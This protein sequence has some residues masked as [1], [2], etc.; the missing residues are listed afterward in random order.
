VGVWV[1]AVP[2]AFLSGLYFKWDVWFVVAAISMEEVVKVTLTLWRT[3]S[4]KW[5][6]NLT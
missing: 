5:L 2:L 1:I 6:R 4:K 3:F